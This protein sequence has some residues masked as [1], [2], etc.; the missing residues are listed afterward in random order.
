MLIKVDRLTAIDFEVFWVLQKQ[1]GYYSVS[2]TVENK[3]REI[4]YK[5][6][7]LEKFLNL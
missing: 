1:R 2:E 4:R 3:E 5:I 6:M 7:S